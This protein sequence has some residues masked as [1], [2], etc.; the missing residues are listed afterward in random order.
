MNAGLK[1]CDSKIRSVVYLMIMHQCHF[2]GFDIV[3]ELYKM[4][5]LGVVGSGGYVWL[6]VIFTTSYESIII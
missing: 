6:W 1:K 4:Q 2:P 5:P 3:L